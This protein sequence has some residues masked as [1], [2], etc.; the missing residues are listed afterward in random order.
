MTNDKLVI[1]Q[2]KW[3]GGLFNTVIETDNGGFMRN[4][5]CM[6]LHVIPKQN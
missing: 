3:I 5:S 4:K 1:N 6:Y 2:T